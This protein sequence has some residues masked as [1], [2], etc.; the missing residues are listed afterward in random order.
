[1][2]QAKKRRQLRDKSEPGQRKRVT[3]AAGRNVN[4]AAISPVGRKSW[5]NRK[6]RR[7]QEGAPLSIFFQFPLF[8]EEADNL[9]SCWPSKFKSKT[10][11]D[12]A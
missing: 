4:G 10:P 9:R 6:F 5:N 7:Y 1:M 3:K 8:S 11:E 12:A 2:Q